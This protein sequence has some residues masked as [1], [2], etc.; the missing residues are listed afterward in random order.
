VRGNAQIQ[1]QVT[2]YI[3]VNCE[4]S[5]SIK[6]TICDDAQLCGEKPHPTQAKYAGQQCVK[7]SKLVSFIDQKGTGM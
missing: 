1:S 7:F 2:F 5:I 6:V 4:G 3:D